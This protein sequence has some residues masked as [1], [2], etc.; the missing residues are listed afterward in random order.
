MKTLKRLFSR[1]SPTNVQ[2]RD[3]DSPRSKYQTQQAPQ[4][5]P[6]VDVRTSP[7]GVGVV[8]LSYMNSWS[9]RQQHSQQTMV[10]EHGKH[11]KTETNTTRLEQQHIQHSGT[12]TPGGVDTCDIGHA[13]A[14]PQVLLQVERLG[15]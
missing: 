3:P 13:V 12:V 10:Q 11:D 7:L 5:E 1:I 6:V 2:P 14:P 9:H 4:P 15:R 8:T